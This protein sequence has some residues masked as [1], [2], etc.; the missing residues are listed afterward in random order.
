MPLRRMTSHTLD[1]LHG[2][3]RMHAVQYRASFNPAHLAAI[4]GGVVFE[5]RVVSVNNNGQF[6][7]GISGTR[8]PM[9]LL[10][11]SDNPDVVNYGG[12]TMSEPFA[13]ASVLPPQ[14]GRLSALVAIGAYELATTEFDKTRT[15]N[16]NDLLTAAPGTNIAV[17]GVLTNDVP[18]ASTPV[19]GVVSRPPYRNSHGQEVLAFWPVYLPQR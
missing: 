18:N 5:G 9:F 14:G 13:W 8:M 11:D 1:G 6:E 15:Y 10:Q 4:S 19:C 2:W 16:I 17:S 12:D 3:P 7:L